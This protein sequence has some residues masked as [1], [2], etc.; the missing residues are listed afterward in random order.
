[1]LHMGQVVYHQQPVTQAVEYP[2]YY[3]L[4]LGHVL[5]VLR[6]VA[7]IRTI[8]K[9]V[10]GIIDDGPAAE[11]TATQP[12]ALF[13]LLAEKS[14]GDKRKL[15]SGDNHPGPRQFTTVGGKNSMVFGGMI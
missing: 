8:A 6:Y 11:L 13:A 10:Q 3:P 1:M 15:I 9:F 5:P 7:V 2:A 12:F 4:H 14:A